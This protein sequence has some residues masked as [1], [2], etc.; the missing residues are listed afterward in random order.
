MS[1]DKPLVSFGVPV[2]NGAAEIRR[3]ID[4]LLAQDLS[5]IEIIVSDNASTDETAAILKEYAQR[6]GRIHAYFNEQDVGL[7]E[8]CNRVFHESRGKYFRWIGAH[9]WIEP[10][11]ASCGVEALEQDS[12]AIA[13]STYIKNHGDEGIIRYEEY[14]GE[15]MESARPERRFA[16]MLWFFH[17]GDT[18][19]DPVYSLIRRDALVRT[20]L[21]RMM[22]NADWMLSADLA[23]MGRFVHIPK[24]LAYRWKPYK[25]AKDLDA[26]LKSYH[27]QRYQQL[28]APP[29]RLS[30]ELISIVLAADL[31]AAQRLSCF[32]STAL[33][34]LRQVWLKSRKGI[35]RFCT[36]RLGLSRKN[37][38][39][40]KS[41]Q[42]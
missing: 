26:R 16:R 4:S 34:F 18:V 24:C 36:K 37:F 29:W 17:A 5:D 1:T 39:F 14:A 2:R 10:Q 42:R 38:S 23:L 28:Y 12:G 9:D 11:Y 7:I 19:Y 32:W 30:R 27:P 20:P 21:I 6:D 31:T 3:C 35:R 8:N 33:F 15:R 13:A 40:A 41:A 22:V 25:K